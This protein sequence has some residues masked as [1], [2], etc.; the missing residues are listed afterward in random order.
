MAEEETP[1]PFVTHVHNIL[2]SIVSNVDA[3]INNQQ[4]YTSNGLFAHK[5]SNCLRTFSTVSGG[6]LWIQGVLDC[7][8]Y[9]YEEFPEKI[10]E[11]L[12]SEP[13][14]TRRM[15]MLGRPDGFMLYDIL[16]VEF[17]SISE[18]LYPNLKI[19]QRLI[20]ARLNFYMVSDNPNISLEIFLKDDYHNKR[21]DMLAYTPVEF[22]YLE[23]LAKTFIIPAILNQFTQENTFNSARVRW[24]AFAMNTNCAITGSYTE[25]PFWYQQFDLRQIRILKGGQPILN[26]DAADNCRF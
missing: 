2:H 21:M 26:F 9:D 8:G 25:N 12:L 1:V 15:K 3:Y 24:I 16:G 17:F 20:S 4:I 22:S 13:F 7:E 10:I 11:T 5:S 14:F 6:Y 23:T 19:R 18:L